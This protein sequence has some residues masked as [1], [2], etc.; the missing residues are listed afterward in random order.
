MNWELFYLICFI[1]GFVFST[2]S[3]LTGTLH[4]HLPTKWH[5][6]V[7]K[8]GVSAK[9]GTSFFNS[10]TLMAFLTWFG[11]MGYLLTR[12]SSMWLGFA[13]ILATLA[14]LVGASIVFWF[15]ARVLLKHDVG[16]DPAEYDMI[17]VLGR[18]SS[19][20]RGGGTG[21]IVFE[22]VGTR[23]SCGARSE[24]GAPIAKGTEIVVTRYER[25]IAYVRTW[26]EISGEA[27][28]DAG[29][30]SKL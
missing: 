6:H 19:S 28:T 7:G 1:L 13:L 8:A 10:F 12:Y 15:F 30:V 17:G 18:V 5:L 22:Q 24:D 23:R 25:G 9:G 3:F 26:D 16:I 2:L 20:I 14:G 21:E 27:N 29:Q 4:L 11:G